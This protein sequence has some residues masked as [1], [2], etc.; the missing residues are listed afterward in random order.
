LRVTSLTLSERPIGLDAV[1]TLCLSF[2]EFLESCKSTGHVCI[3]IKVK[4]SSFA[5]RAS[6]TLAAEK[7]KVP[8]T[9][10]KKPE[11]THS[12]HSASVTDTQKSQ[13]ISN[14]CFF[15]RPNRVLAIKCKSLD[16]M[17][18]DVVVPRNPVILDKREELLLI[19][20]EPCP[21]PLCRLGVE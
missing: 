3:W 21:K 18:G 16:C 8:L 14:S 10:K 19:L 1:L 17:L 12:S 2:F 4:F 6:V 9:R 5:V 11:K 13:V 20:Q 15:K 7:F